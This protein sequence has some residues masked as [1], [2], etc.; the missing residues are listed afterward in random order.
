MLQ[1]YVVG[2]DVGTSHSIRK[3]FC[4]I[5]GLFGYLAEREGFEPLLVGDQ[6]SIT[7]AKLPPKWSSARPGL[8][9][10]VSTKPRTCG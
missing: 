1:S 2:T 8:S 3:Y 9:D 4:K 10:P 5:N 7:W 6:R